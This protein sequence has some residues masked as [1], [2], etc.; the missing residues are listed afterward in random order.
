MNLLISLIFKSMFV[1]LSGYIFNTDL[2][3]DNETK[4]IKR[5]KFCLNSIISSL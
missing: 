2:I 3:G 1:L 4:K 5:L